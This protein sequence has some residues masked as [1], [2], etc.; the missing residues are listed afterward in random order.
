LVRR[1]TAPPEKLNPELYSDLTI[2]SAPS[3]PQVG[4]QTITFDR[5]MRACVFVKEFTESFA[6]LDIGKD[7]R[8]QLNYDQFLKFCL[9][10]P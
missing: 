2:A 5:F 9:M 10:L 7:G 4:D 3:G 8:V 1:A 6:G